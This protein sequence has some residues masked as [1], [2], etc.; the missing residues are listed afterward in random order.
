MLPNTRTRSIILRK[1]A[2]SQRNPL[3]LFKLQ[4]LACDNRGDATCEE[5]NAGFS[6]TLYKYWGFDCDYKQ[7]AHPYSLRGDHY[8]SA[9]EAIGG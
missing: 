6:G 2:Y 9:P 5:H 8:C 4:V 3:L 7:P 1:E